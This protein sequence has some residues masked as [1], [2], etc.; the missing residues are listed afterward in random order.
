[1]ITTTAQPSTPIQEELP[2][3]QSAIGYIRVSTDSQE[4]F[5]QE[6]EIINYCKIHRIE[7][8]AILRE[9]CGISGRADA[10]KKGPREALEY[11]LKLCAG[12]LEAIERP[13]YAELLRRVQAER[14]A[15][16]I[17]YALDR[18]SRDRIELLLL[19]R[20]LACHDCTIVNVAQGGTIDTSS[21]MGNFLYGMSALTAQLEVD[22]TR[23]RTKSSLSHKKANGVHIGRPPA[24]WK[25][26]GDAFVHDPESW[27][28][29]KRVFEL[30]QSGKNYREIKELTGVPIGSIA[31]YCH[32]YKWEPAQN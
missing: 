6:A 21:A 1:M 5:R 18:L 19:E 8:L 20:L 25:K 30:R 29:I 9:D 15:I 16:A 24:G 26:V 12:A 22:Q 2:P 13:G 3:M 17:F 27:E 11:Y 14:P 28:L 4:T 7:L 23:E 31:A 10:L 32:A